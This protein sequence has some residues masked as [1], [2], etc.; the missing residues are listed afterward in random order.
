MR[1]YALRPAENDQALR[2]AQVWARLVASGAPP[3][4]G[5]MPTGRPSL[6]SPELVA[7]ICERISCGESL[8]AI[9]RDPTMPCRAAVFRWL[10]E[11]PEFRGQYE[12]ACEER[13]E[14]WAERIIEIADVRDG[15]GNVQSRKLQ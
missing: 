15:D 1:W 13:T 11:H 8:A 6:Y 9:C 3:G 5:P 2:L 4:G 12:Q 7:E 10:R 14:F